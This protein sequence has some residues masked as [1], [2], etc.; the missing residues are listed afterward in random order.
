MGRRIQAIT[1]ETIQHHLRLAAQGVLNGMRTLTK[2]GVIEE[3]VAQEVTRLIRCLEEKGLAIS[4]LIKS[5]EKTDELVQGDTGDFERL[6]RELL[7]SVAIHFEPEIKALKNL[8]EEN[9]KDIPRKIN[10][11]EE[12]KQKTLSLFYGVAQNGINRLC[13]FLDRAE[14]NDPLHATNSVG[15]E[16]WNGFDPK[17]EEE[18]L[19]HDLT[20]HG[21]IPHQGN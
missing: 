7:R 13:H 12:R 9:A 1:H 21:L 3:A 5:R 15:A 6:T 11:E 4:N 16:T 2:N 14:G 20:A 8:W 19:T 17:K 10:Q 18:D